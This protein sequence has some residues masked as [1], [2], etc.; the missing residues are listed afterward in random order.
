M[1]QQNRHQLGPLIF[2]SGQTSSFLGPLV[3]N[4]ETV[5]KSRPKISSQLLNSRLKNSKTLSELR[6]H[7]D[8]NHSIMEAV[9]D[10]VICVAGGRF[11]T[12]SD[13]KLR[14]EFRAF[15]L[16]AAGMWINRP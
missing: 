8:E 15:Y 5:S 11:G 10:S 14:N 13:E 6:Q 3:F 16:L 2:N 12:T 7:I 9:H 4:S 1:N